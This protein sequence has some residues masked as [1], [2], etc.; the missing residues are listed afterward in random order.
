MSFA[1][2]E[3]LS[4]LLTRIRGFVDERLIPLESVIL[5]PGSDYRPVLAEVRSEVKSLGFWA[6]HLPREHGGMGLSLMEFA[7]VSE[8]LG[9]TLLGHHAFF[10][11]APD[12]GNIEVLIEHGSDAQKERFLAPLLTG[13]THS[14]FAMTEPDTAGSNPLMLATQAKREG[15]HYVINGHKWFA[16]AADGAAFAIVMAVTQPEAENPYGKTSMLLVPTDTKGYIQVRN[17]PVMGEPHGGYFGHSELRFEDCRVPAENLLGPDGAGFL[18]AQQRLGPG[19]IH[20]CMRWIGICERAF[21][22]MCRR[23]ATREIAPGKPLA[24]RQIVQQ[25]IAESR[26]EIDAARLLVLDTADT[27][28]R[29]G[30]S[31]ARV[32]ISEIKYFV[33]GVLDRVL[34][35]AIQSHGALGITDDTPLAYWYRHER[36]ARIYDGADEVHQSVVARQVLKGFGLTLKR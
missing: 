20:H 32:A 9:R 4:E 31:A 22:L 16:T 34:D 1:P 24:S 17:I 3:Q 35:R 11:H 33:A 8:E 10:C 2:N 14:C 36:G 23:A 27:I 12:V 26:A 25:W 30:T 5:E 15:E 19:R 13:D 21:E 7:R 29:V 6:P 18:I 28:D